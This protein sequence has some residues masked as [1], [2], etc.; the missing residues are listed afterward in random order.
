MPSPVKPLKHTLTGLTFALMTSNASVASNEIHKPLIKSEDPDTT[1]IH[2]YLQN[3]TN[4]TMKLSKPTKKQINAS[5]PINEFDVPAKGRNDYAAD[6]PKFFSAIAFGKATELTETFAYASGNK[7]CL[8]TASIEV[9]LE[10]QGDD[11]ERV[12]HWSGKGKSTG[13]EAADCST[14][15]LE[16]Q[17][18]YPNSMSIEFTME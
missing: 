10:K 17:K 5:F 8:Y 15:I 16:V 9:R 2:Y 4:S 18:G 13:A 6:F 14:E 1:T 7:E 3:L 11:V 12:P